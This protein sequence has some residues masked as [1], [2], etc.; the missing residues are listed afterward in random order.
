MIYEEST[1]TDRYQTTIPSPI[2]CALNLKK[3]DKI[4]YSIEANGRVFLSPIPPVESDPVFDAFLAFLEQDMIN[5][6]QQ[7]RPLPPELVERGQMLVAGMDIDLD[8]ALS[9]EDE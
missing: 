2:R 7:L 4:Y 5:N 1:L 3:R 9:A 6:P 8:S